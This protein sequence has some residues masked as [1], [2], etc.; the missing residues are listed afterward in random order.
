MAKKKASWAKERAKQMKELKA[1]HNKGY[2]PHKETK[3]K[4]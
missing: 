2:M 3:F 1:I 4:F